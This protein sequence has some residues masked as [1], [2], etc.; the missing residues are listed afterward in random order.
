MIVWP[1]STT[2]PTLCS[3]VGCPTPDLD[4]PQ[5]CPRCGTEQT[6]S[7]NALDALLSGAHLAPLP[8]TQGY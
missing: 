2:T 3:R 8:I 6:T 5:E 1:P 7:T 4:G